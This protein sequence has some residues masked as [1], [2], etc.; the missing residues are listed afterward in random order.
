MQFYVGVAMLTVGVVWWVWSYM[1]A[2]PKLAGDD[3]GSLFKDYLRLKDHVEAV[4]TPEQKAAVLA[5]LPCVAM[6]KPE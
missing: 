4:G 6:E 2:L 1:P 3:R 5:I